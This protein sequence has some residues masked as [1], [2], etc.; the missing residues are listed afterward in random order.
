MAKP[1]TLSKKLKGNIK[2]KSLEELFPSMQP[3]E[4]TVIVKEGKDGYD[5][6][7][8]RDGSDGRDGQ[9]GVSFNWKGIWKPDNSYTQ[10]D[11]VNYQG[12]VYI[13]LKESKGKHPGLRKEYWDLVMAAAS[14]GGGGGGAG[15][16]YTEVT[17]ATY[18]ISAGSLI[19]GHNIFGVN[20]GEDA[21]VNL[22]ATTDPTKIVVVKNEMQSFTVTVLP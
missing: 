2:P 6:R 21:V 1:V 15:V 12:S 7:D 14:G 22:P 19:V 5:G 10:N 3:P 9:D 17:T 20:A 13:A 18:D 16:T 4:P 11:T 8:G